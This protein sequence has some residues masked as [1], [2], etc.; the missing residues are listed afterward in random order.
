MT[1]AIS[2]LAAG[3]YLAG[4][5]P[6]A[7]HLFCRWR[8]SRVPLCGT[9][10]HYSYGCQS[11]YSSAPTCTRPHHTNDCYRRRKPDLSH[12]S[13]DTDA[14]AA[15]WA[16]FAALAWPFVLLGLLIMASPPEL[17]GERLQR[18]EQLE[19]DLGIGG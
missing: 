16:V 4:F 9:E 19:R 14:N 7:R 8:P 15:G 6:T 18:L 13:I 10:R 2:V 12:V 5:L 17:P 3:I 11:C 1:A